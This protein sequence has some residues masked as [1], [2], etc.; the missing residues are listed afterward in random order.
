MHYAVVNYTTGSIIHTGT[1]E[2]SCA[3]ALEPGTCYGKGAT[4]VEAS[5]QAMSRAAAVR[6]AQLKRRCA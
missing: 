5:N 1:S 6:L 2:A 4:S 3:V